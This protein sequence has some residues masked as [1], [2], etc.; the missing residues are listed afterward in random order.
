MNDKRPYLEIAVI[1]GEPTTVHITSERVTIGRYPEHNDIALQPDPQHLVT[2]VHHCSVERIDGIW[3]VVDNGSVNKTFLRK[4]AATEV[5]MGKAVL[6]DQDTILILGR[7]SDVSE[8]AYWE[9]TFYDPMR[10][11]AADVVSRL[12]FLEYDWVQAKLL[13]FDG[14]SR[15]EIKGLRPQEQKLIRYMDQRNRRNGFVPVMCTYDELIEAV[16]DEDAYGHTEAD[17]NRLVWE[18]RKKL[19]IDAKDPQFLQTVRG[20][21]YRLVTR[22]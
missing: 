9:I 13:R 15:M 6:S 19:E 5:V 1:D 22:G 20:L 12:A 16:W 11:Q 14:R 10:T 8:P 7:L 18:L 21:G 2:R 3:W 4:G 17:I